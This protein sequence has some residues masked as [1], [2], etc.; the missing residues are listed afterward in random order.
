LLITQ[1]SWLLTLSP[2]CQITIPKSFQ[3]H[4]FAFRRGNLHSYLL[5]LFREHKGTKFFALSSPPSILHPTSRQGGQRYEVFDI[6]KYRLAPPPPCH[7]SKI[8]PNLTTSLTPLSSAP[9][10]ASPLFRECKGT[11]FFALS[12]PLYFPLCQVPS[13][14]HP[15]SRQGAQRYEVFRFV[16]SFPLASPLSSPPSEGRQS[17]ELSGIC[18]PPYS[19][20]PIPRWGGGQRYEVFRFV[21]P[22]FYSASLFLRERKGTKDEAIG[23]RR[24]L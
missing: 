20:R 22:P 5:S 1:S 13:I 23:V 15:T 7:F 16:K 6:H 12:S 19:Q 18:K 3:T 11:K 21:K 10:P 2:N 24:L 14:F 4:T 17:Y 8:M 9:P